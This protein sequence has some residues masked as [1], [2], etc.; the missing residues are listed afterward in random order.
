M[1]N[2]IGIIAWAAVA[3]A[4]CVSAPPRP[5]PAPVVADDPTPAYRGAGDPVDPGVETSY[6]RALKS[7]LSGE[8]VRQTEEERR[9]K[10]KSEVRDYVDDLYR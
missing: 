8:E 7:R 4:G 1:R 10:E 3:L 5:A 2:R 6:T 9:E